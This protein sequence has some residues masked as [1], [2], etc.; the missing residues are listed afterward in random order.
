MIVVIEIALLP[1]LTLVLAL[2]MSGAPARSADL[3]PA[4][5][6]DTVPAR[7]ADSAAPGARP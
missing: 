1:T 7:S 3:V 5:S 4:R 6:A 2:L